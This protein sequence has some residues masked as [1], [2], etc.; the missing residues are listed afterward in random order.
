M[1]R[2]DCFP[3]H[4]SRRRRAAKTFA[5]ALLLGAPVAWAQTQFEI[6]TENMQDL[7]IGVDA[8]GDLRPPQLG[9][10]RGCH[11]STIVVD[12]HGLLVAEREEGVVVRAGQGEPIAELRLTPGL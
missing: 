4:V 6:Y 11:G 10:H 8:L 7:G 3:T 1:D 2:Y 9:P 12:E 5:L